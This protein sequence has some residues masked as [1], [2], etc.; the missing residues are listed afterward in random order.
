MMNCIC[1]VSRLIIGRPIDNSFKFN[2][3]IHNERYLT[4]F[5]STQRSTYSEGEDDDFLNA[6][7]SEYPYHYEMFGDHRATCD[8]IPKLHY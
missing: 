5:L 4:K 8:L 7:I 2:D 3:M 6:L 1:D